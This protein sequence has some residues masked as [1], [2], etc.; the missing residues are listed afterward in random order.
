MIVNMLTEIFV[1]NAVEQVMR[2]AAVE[3]WNSITTAAARTNDMI[4]NDTASITQSS[5]RLTLEAPR[6]FLVLTEC[7]RTGTRAKKKFTKLMNAMMMTRKAM[8][9]RV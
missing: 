5:I 9:S 6:T 8:A 1:P 7:T 4:I 2:F 3:V